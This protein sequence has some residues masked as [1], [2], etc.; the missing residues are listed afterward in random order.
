MPG[1]AQLFTSFS[2]PV[3]SGRQ[4]FFRGVGDGSGIYVGDGGALGV[5]AKTGDPAP[6]GS[7]FS[8]FGQFVSADSGE[9]AFSASGS[10]FNGLFVSGSTGICRVI[11]TDT[12]LDGKDVIQLFMGRDS[13]ATGKLGFLAVFSDG[14]RGIYLA[15]KP[16]IASSP[17]QFPVGAIFLLLDDSDE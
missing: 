5:I 3:I 9:L 4:V 1:G 6:G 8:G 7:T 10:G 16:Q 13:Y 14:S 12:S 17:N 2:I 11:D 15:K